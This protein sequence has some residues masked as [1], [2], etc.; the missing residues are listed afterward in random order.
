MTFR[1]PRESAYAFKRWMQQAQ[2]EID[3]GIRKGATVKWRTANPAK[4]LIGRFKAKILRMEK[5]A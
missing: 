3:A 1:E 5:R 2:D 4:V